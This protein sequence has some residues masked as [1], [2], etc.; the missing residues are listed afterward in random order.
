MALKPAQK[1]VAKAKALKDR[2]TATA[3]RF[4]AGK[5][6]RGSGG[7]FS[8]TGAE[9]RHASESARRKAE[10]EAT[11]GRQV[12]TGTPKPKPAPPQTPSHSPTSPAASQYFPDTR[13]TTDGM[14]NMLW[15]KTIKGEV[16]EGGKPSTILQAAVMLH[17]MGVLTQKS[18]MKRLGEEVMK[19]KDQHK[20]P[21]F[22]EAMKKVIH[23][24]ATGTSEYAKA[25]GAKPIA[26]KLAPTSTAPAPAKP[27]QAETPPPA[28]VADSIK[29]AYTSE[30]EVTQ[31][32]RQART[33]TRDQRI[34]RLLARADKTRDTRA[35]THG[36]DA[37]TE[38][39]WQRGAVLERMRAA[40]VAPAQ[41]K[42]SH[43]EA[44]AG[45]E[46]ET[47]DR[48]RGMVAEAKARRAPAPAPKPT[49]R[50]VPGSNP[51]S[52]TPAWRTTAPRP[53]PAAK[54]AA[55]VGAYVKPFKMDRPAAPATVAKPSDLGGNTEYIGRMNLAD[56]HVDPTRFQYKQHLTDLKTGTTE[57]LKDVRTWNEKLAGVVSVW[58]DPANGRAYVINGHHR[59]ELAMRLGVKHIPVREIFADN[60]VEARGIG[61]LQNI[62][63]GKGTTLDA[64]K[65]LRDSGL[66]AQDLKDQGLSLK[67]KQ[68]HTAAGAATVT[69]RVWEHV[70][71]ERLNIDHAGEIG[72]AN[73]SPESQH[74]ISKDLVERSQANKAI[75]K[76]YLRESIDE[77]KHAPTAAGRGQG[78]MFGDPEEER[79]LTG[80]ARELRS[81]IAES[82]GRDQ[83]I[84]SAATRN[85]DRLE[86]AGNQ[87]DR[88]ASGKMASESGTLLDFFHQYKHG[89]LKGAIDQAAVAHHE[90][91]TRQAKAK[92]MDDL[93]A[94][95]RRRIREHLDA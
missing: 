47:L 46:R 56:L 66:T 24:W 33:E 40:G 51:L 67:D 42:A 90:A 13:G 9:A 11:H 36:W 16:N 3:H 39:A 52:P 21:A 38:L 6:P 79:R 68:I 74:A 91:P 84:F 95:I 26:A 15:E 4:E 93:D 69:D 8:E 77:E 30:P 27:T 75:S 55:K 94:E 14:Y 82:L 34:E 25:A 70:Y 87:I 50:P 85:A 41:A 61:A 17:K 37:R 23:G 10:R 63:E 32:T 12:S 62:S 7:K 5:H 2:I 65:Y 45:F 92:V 29:R 60:H 44:V 57:A 20:G 18:Q 49:A 76:E 35:K 78:N 73:L 19:A 89:L 22:Q 81:K 71:A 48:L 59:H 64:A 31:P 80:T 54:P 72:H 86:E 43:A 83:R 53:K 58:K 1:L 28:P 88:E